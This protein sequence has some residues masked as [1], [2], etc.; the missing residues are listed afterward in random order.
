MIFS[1]G[2]IEE[3]YDQT[4][5]LEARTFTDGRT[6]HHLD[7]QLDEQ[8]LSFCDRLPG[9]TPSKAISSQ[10][11]LYPTETGYREDHFL[12]FKNNQKEVY[13]ELELVRQD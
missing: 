2:N 11:V 10:K 5:Q 6:V 13:S 4:G 8:R 1:I 9:H 7:L 12:I 3:N